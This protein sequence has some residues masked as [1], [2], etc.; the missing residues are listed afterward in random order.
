MLDESKNMSR[1]QA[2]T[3]AAERWKKDLMDL[4]GRNQLLYYRDLKSGTLDLT[5]DSALNPEEPAVDRLLRGDGVKLSSIFRDSGSREISVKKART[6]ASKA[7]SS[8]DER[9]VKTL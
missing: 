4:S 6:I 9:G 5:H 8:F 3:S 2:V 1:I 7:R